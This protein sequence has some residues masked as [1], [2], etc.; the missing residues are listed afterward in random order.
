MTFLHILFYSNAWPKYTYHVWSQQNQSF[1][2][3]QKWRFCNDCDFTEALNQCFSTPVLR[4]YLPECF[5]FP[6]RYLPQRVSTFTLL[7]DNT[8]VF[9]QSNNT[10]N[11]NQYHAHCILIQNKVMHK[12]V[13]K[14]YINLILKKKKK[15][16]C[17]KSPFSDDILHINTVLYSYIQ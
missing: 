10:S 7:Q 9:I 4:T 1:M 12:L 15:W 3:L 14:T 13:S 16:C 6:Y 5:S 17:K 11:N 2:L 8:S